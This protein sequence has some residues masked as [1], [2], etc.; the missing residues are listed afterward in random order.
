MYD[1]RAVASRR[2]VFTLLCVLLPVSAGNFST[3]SATINDA[4][5][6]RNFSTTPATINHTKTAISRNFST[7][8][9]VV[10][11]TETPSPTVSNDIR[12]LSFF[13]VLLAIV[14]TVFISVMVVLASL[15]KCGCHAPAKPTEQPQPGIEE[16]AG[17]MASNSKAAT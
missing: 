11:N 17:L 15:N 12:S 4:V 16:A 6:S 7:V 13:L 10:N 14:F 5:I 9:T 8:S 1:G 3:T 2:I